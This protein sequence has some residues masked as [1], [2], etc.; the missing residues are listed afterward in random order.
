MFQHRDQSCPH[1]SLITFDVPPKGQALGACATCPSSHRQKA[2]YS[3][4]Q[5]LKYK[6]SFFFVTHLP[7][8]NTRKHKLIFVRRLEPLKNVG[9]QTKVLFQCFNDFQPR[10][11]ADGCAGLSHVHRS[12]WNQ[13][14]EDDSW[15]PNEA[16]HCNVCGCGWLVCK[17]IPI[18]VS[19]EML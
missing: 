19:T 10:Y 17:Q 1:S 4:H 2:L 5:V 12:S 7:Q 6:K 16:S 15:L 9:I 13:Q 8:S 3:L 11:N 14:A 18:I